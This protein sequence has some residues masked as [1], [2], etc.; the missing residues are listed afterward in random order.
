MSNFK[1]I[2]TKAVVGKGKK[3]TIDN[4][5]VELTTNPSLLTI[6]VDTLS[7][8]LHAIGIS[9]MAINIVETM[10]L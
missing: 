2:V 1:E 5:I 6:V 9:I 7:D 10:I 4:H 8:S 3:T